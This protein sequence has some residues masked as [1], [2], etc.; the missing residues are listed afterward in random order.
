MLC[1][2]VSILAGPIPEHLITTDLIDFSGVSAMGYV[3][4]GYRVTAPTNNWVSLSSGGGIRATNGGSY[5]AVG[6]AGA[7]ITLTHADGLPFEIISLD[8]AEYSTVAIPSFV[9]FEGVKSDGSRV[10]L[11]FV[12]DGIIDGD[13][14]TNDFQTLSFPT[15]WSDIISLQILNG[16]VALDN[17]TVRGSSL[18]QFHVADSPNLPL[19]MLGVLESSPSA[20]NW[21][22]LS[23]KDGALALRRQRYSYD[24]VFRFRFDLESGPLQYRGLYSSTSGQN[25]DTLEIAYLLNGALLW[26]SGPLTLE[27]ARIG[28]NGVIGIS[29]PRPAGGKVLFLNQAA[30]NHG[31][32]IVAIAGT[33]GIET[34]LTS[35]TLLPDGG[36][37]KSISD[38]LIFTGTSL[39]IRSATTKSTQRYIISFVGGPLRLSPGEGDSIPGSSLKIMGRPALRWLNDDGAGFVAN[40]SGGNGELLQ[41][42]MTPSGIWT[43]TIRPAPAF[44]AKVPL[45]GAGFVLRSQTVEILD[46]DSALLC[47]GPIECTDLPPNNLYGLVAELADGKRHLL[48]RAGRE[49]P[50][51]GQ[52]AS[53]SRQALIQGGCLFVIATNPEGVTA[54]FRGKIPE[55]EPRLKAGVF[56]ATTDGTVRFIVENLS[57]GRNY[58][59]ERAESPAGPWSGAQVFTAGSP[60]RSVLAEFVRGQRAFFR[61]AEVA[62]DAP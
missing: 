47:G 43:T 24:P 16:K 53:F 25:P 36:F 23:L 15:G 7:P 6:T 51:F 21:G 59:I 52:V 4:R 45:P 26:Q 62:I 9:D 3:H 8:L 1:L 34:V 31:N 35:T 57:H 32:P 41:I 28:Q 39:A 29:Y 14:A 2:P 46:E 44:G 11:R 56:V 22:V 38:E 42:L 19:E 20:N 49:I 17:I 40:S 12:P 10:N 30:E 33:N 13:G 18:D 60:S 50:S 27:L 58:H 48:L 5:L 54:L 55:E 61:V 37:P